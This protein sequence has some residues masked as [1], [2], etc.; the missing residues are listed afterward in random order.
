MRSQR[1]TTLVIIADMIA[2]TMTIE[3]L[4]TKAVELIREPSGRCGWINSRQ[5]PDRAFQT[6]NSRGIL[7]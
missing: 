7:I 6:L 3:Q 5:L 4:F 2:T 1:L